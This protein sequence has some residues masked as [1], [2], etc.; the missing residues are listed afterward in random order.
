MS[1]SVSNP[2]DEMPASREMDCIIA[3]K[4]FGWED[5]SWDCEAYNYTGHPQNHYR[6]E[7][8]PYYTT[9]LKDAW[10]IVKKLG[11]LGW[12]MVFM[13]Q[14][15]HSPECPFEYGADFAK[16]GVRVIGYGETEPLAL[17]RGALK[18]VVAE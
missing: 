16:E 1:E 10:K 17:C 3:E 13:N 15:S 6:Y 7:Q 9:D 5:V 18:I 4:F 11:E 8:V 12:G 14:Y 2:I